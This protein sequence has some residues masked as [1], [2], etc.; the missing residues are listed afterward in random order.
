MALRRP[1]H[2]E[3]PVIWSAGNA[4]DEIVGD[5]K[6]ILGGTPPSPPRRTGAG[7][8]G[9]VRGDIGRPTG[10]GLATAV[11][12]LHLDRLAAA[13]REIGLSDVS[14]V[15]WFRQL[16]P[17]QQRARLPA[18]R[19]GCPAAPRAIVAERQTSASRSRSTRRRATRLLAAAPVSGGRLASAPG[20]GA[21]RTSAEA[22][23]PGR[24]SW[25]HRCS[26]LG[27]GGPEVVRHESMFRDR[28]LRQPGNPPSSQLE[29]A[30]A[31]G[32][33]SPSTDPS[34]VA[35]AFVARIAGCCGRTIN[36][37]S[38]GGCG[39][40][41]R[42]GSRGPPA[43]FR[44][45]LGVG[46]GHFRLVGCRDSARPTPVPRRYG[47]V[48]GEDV[49][50]EGEEIRVHRKRLAM[51]GVR[52]SSLLVARPQAPAPAG[53]A[54]AGTWSVTRSSSAQQRRSR[55]PLGP[56][57]EPLESPA[58][59]RLSLGRR[60]RGIP[61]PTSTRPRSDAH[62]R[63]RRLCSSQHTQY[64][65]NAELIAEV[66]VSVDPLAEVQGR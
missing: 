40:S 37:R 62:E 47:L 8:A 2:A 20:L 23:T 7:E 34:T 42:R 52:S 29:T 66:P 6:P 13:R 31:D 27:G 32:G 65:D 21:K 1:V 28:V 30:H 49:D 10:I 19:R 45:W 51:L 26:Q 33:G 35:S 22:R 44:D 11:R 55:S 15:A 18:Y 17:L 38:P 25:G 3:P 14:R 24:R 48:H 59:S 46:A 56:V 43:C 50:L 5:M 60:S 36:G 57:T 39:S 58:S 63:R 61:R 53:G 64:R 16:L 9:D 4:R 41:P 12:R 54:A